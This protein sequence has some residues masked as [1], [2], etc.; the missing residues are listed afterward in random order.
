M[1]DLC[2]QMRQMTITVEKKHGIEFK[3]KWRV[4][5]GLKLIQWGCRLCGIS[6]EDETE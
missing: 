5:V 3:N 2:E 6:F 4:F 1:I